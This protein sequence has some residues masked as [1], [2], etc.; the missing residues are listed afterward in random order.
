MGM[1]PLAH[2]KRTRPFAD[3]RSHGG[4]ATSLPELDIQACRS[5]T[6]T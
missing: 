5:A 6:T 4:L 2:D 3:R 1:V